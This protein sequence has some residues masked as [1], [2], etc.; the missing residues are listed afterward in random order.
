MRVDGRETEVLVNAVH[1]QVANR[2]FHILSLFVYFVP[3]QIKG[4]DEE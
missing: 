4:L 3:C 2:M 1:Q